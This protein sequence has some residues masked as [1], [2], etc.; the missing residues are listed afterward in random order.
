MLD[1][2]QAGSNHMIAH[3]HVGAIWIAIGN[4]AYD[5][6]VLVKRIFRVSGH[7]LKGAEWCESMSKISSG[8]GDA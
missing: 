4:S 2:L 3:G 5:V 7:K 1:D 6:I 8:S